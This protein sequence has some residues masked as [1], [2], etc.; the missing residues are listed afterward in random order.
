MLIS[1]RKSDINYFYGVIIDKNLS[2]YLLKLPLLALYFTSPIKN[3]TIKRYSNCNWTKIPMLVVA[4]EAADRGITRKITTYCC[5]VL[6]E[7]DR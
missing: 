6:A 5:I 2:S 7:M 1:K 3:S 4:S